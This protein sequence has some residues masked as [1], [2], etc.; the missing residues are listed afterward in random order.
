MKKKTV[1]F[2]LTVLMLFSGLPLPAGAGTDGN[3]TATQQQFTDMPQNYA[4]TALLKAVANGLLVGDGSRIYPGDNL[5]RA[6]MAVIIARSF[7]AAA[8]TD[9]TEFIDVDSNAWY[10]D[11]L[12]SAVA[13]K[14]IA[15]HGNRMNPNTPITREQV[16]AILARALKLPP[17]DKAEKNFEDLSEVSDWAK[18]DIYAMIN[19]GYVNGGDGKLHLHQPITRQ[20]FA[21][22][23][24]NVVN[25]YVRTGDEV[26]SVEKGNVMVNIPGA[27]LKDMTIHGD[28]ILGDG[29]GNGTVTLQN[30]NVT[31]RTVVR[32]GGVNSIIISGASRIPHLVLARTD[33]SV[34]VLAKDGAQIDAIYVAD[35]KGDV[36]FEGDA[37]DITI[38]APGVNVILS[39]NVGNVYVK[40]TS[41]VLVQRGAVI[42][43]ITLSAPDISVS[44]NGLVRNV[45]L[46]SKATNATITV[47]TSSSSN[48]T[49]IVPDTNN[50][51]PPATFH[52]DVLTTANTI[53]TGNTLKLD[54][55]LINNSGAVISQAVWRY[56]SENEGIATV[57]DAGTITGV[58]VGNTNIRITTEYAGKFLSTTIAIRV[59]S[60]VVEVEQEELFTIQPDDGGI[61]QFPDAFKLGNN[62]FVTFSKHMDAAVSGGLNGMRIS[63]DN[64]LTFD[65]YQESPDFPMNGNITN[66]KD[67]RLYFVQTGSSYG[68]DWLTCFSW[69]SDDLGETW[70]KRTGR[71]TTTGEP[72]TRVGAGF[73]SIVFCGTPMVESDG[74]M[75]NSMYGM[76]LQDS[77]WRVLWAKS[78][79][80]GLNW[81]VISTIASGLPSVPL[82]READGFAEPCVIRCSDG[83]LLAVMRTRTMLPFLQS[84]SYDNG[85][86][87]TEPTK[88]PNAAGGQIPD[89][90]AGSV[91][92]KLLML[93]NGML[94]LSYGR[95]DVK[96]LISVDGCGYQ[97]DY[98]TLIY[99][100]PTN[101][102]QCS[103]MTGIVETEPNRLLIVCDTGAVAYSPPVKS[104]WGK[105]V[106]IHTASSNIRSYSKA[107]IESNID[108]IPLSSARETVHLVVLDQ[109]GRML[110]AKDYSVSYASD[111][112]AVVTV[113]ENGLLVPIG[114]G[115]ATITATINYQGS[116]HKIEK[117]MSVIDDDIIT[118]LGLKAVETDIQTSEQTRLIAWVNNG[119]GEEVKE[120]VSFVYESS[121]PD[122]VSVTSDGIIK[123]GSTAGRATI[124]I[125]ATKGSVTLNGSVDITVVRNV[126]QPITFEED[127]ELPPGFTT[128]FGQ[129]RIEPVGEN[130]VLRVFD[131][132]NT[133]AATVEFVGTNTTTKILEAMVY[134]QKLSKGFVLLMLSKSGI[135]EVAYQINITADGAVNYYTDKAY[136]LLGAGTIKQG[137]WYKFRM[138]AD[139]L[140]QTKLY[141]DDEYI[142]ILPLRTE[143]LVSVDR[144]QFIVGSTAGVQDILYV[145]NFTFFE[146]NE[147][148]M[149]LSSFTAQVDKTTLPLDSTAQISTLAHNVYGL[150][151]FDAEYSFESVDE[152][153]AMVDSTGKITGVAPGEVGIKVMAKKGSVELEKTISIRIVSDALGSVTA[154]IS[155]NPIIA[156]T[157]ATI[158]AY[159]KTSDGEEIDGAAFTYESEDISVATVDGYGVVTGVAPGI[160]NINVSASYRSTTITTSVAF[161]VLS[162][163]EDFENYG[164]GEVPVDFT[165]ANLIGHVAMDVGYTGKGYEIWDNIAGSGATAITTIAKPKSTSK[166]VVFKLKQSLNTAQAGV[167]LL[168]FKGDDGKEAFYI[169]INPDG[170]VYSSAS[171]VIAGASILNNKWYEISLNLTAGMPSD[172]T[173]K[174]MDTGV[175]NTYTL[176]PS[177]TAAA[178]NIASLTITCGR[179]NGNTDKAYLDDFKFVDKAD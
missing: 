62:I 129:A 35:G 176:P 150:S 141:I 80:N 131:E 81:E 68:R 145:D 171:A 11:G 165:A 123:A 82:D 37:S 164:S 133:N 55:Q 167:L 24:D 178:T 151:I 42:N 157:T 43:S 1:A 76:Y 159:A 177:V 153:I 44:G 130:K 78:T 31:G 71:I 19:A 79:D 107:Y 136:P 90:D 52:I 10:Y 57:D 73:S 14:I 27:K 50:E 117:Q 28:L 22:V 75:Y 30:V 114:V 16:F 174:D 53:L 105:F 60:R 162:D 172:I 61:N 36:I 59:L 115:S 67:G 32:G 103:G 8:S 100:D 7:G 104:I 21:V 38:T 175:S 127:T 179:S 121:A 158:T 169:K 13:M 126:E 111:N 92:P 144:M 148:S 143:S 120:G 77:K 54:S 66:L 2:I 89:A 87:W 113:D 5:T 146:P 91:Y 39:G 17:A 69:V 88:L 12:A 124:N 83:S 63:R 70:T 4:T 173:I 122:I 160:T 94:A 65:E 125:S 93:S 84:R 64:G 106:N 155:K 74:T 142:G 86:T 97:W 108:E 137:V 18:K 98:L 166:T 135:K 20:D 161:E 6:Q 85:L 25:T 3:V 170:T 9:L 168:Q 29:I 147:E 119:L 154:A 140:G 138:D 118:E 96:L 99:D 72:F 26:Q 48:Q 139:C 51:A 95:P 47:P 156:G 152:G 132:S 110:L 163:V 58:S 112:T 46:E 41:S 40:S 128:I 101:L 15:G 49:E 34:R 116:E 109:D 33:G 45:T 134:P 23:L 149:T 56:E 102:T